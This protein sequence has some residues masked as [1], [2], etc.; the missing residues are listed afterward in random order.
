MQT[1]LFVKAILVDNFGTNSK[2][3][4][5]ECNQSNALLQKPVLG[6]NAKGKSLQR[7]KQNVKMEVL[8]SNF[9]EQFS[10]VESAI[11][12]SDFIGKHI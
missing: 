10:V 3:S 9:D 1:K 7:C 8:K 12:R 4:R 2:R 5:L 6:C 11:K